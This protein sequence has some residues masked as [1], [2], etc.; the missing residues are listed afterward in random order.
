MPRKTQE[1]QPPQPSLQLQNPPWPSLGAHPKAAREM[2]NSQAWKHFVSDLEGWKARDSKILIQGG[3]DQ[4]TEDKIRGALIFIEI[5]QA[6]K[7]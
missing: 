3:A 5:V 7:V 2:L 4:R 6:L 1:P